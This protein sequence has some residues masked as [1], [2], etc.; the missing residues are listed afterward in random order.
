MKLGLVCARACVWPL[1]ALAGLAPR[2]HGLPLQA[3]LG[4][5]RRAGTGAGVRRRG[6]RGQRAERELTTWTAGQLC[7][8]MRK[9]AEE[10]RGGGDGDG[11]EQ[12]QG[13]RNKHS[14]IRSAAPYITNKSGTL[15]DS[16]TD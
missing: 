9:G 13:G 15:V 2:R 14:F 3:D 4:V 12:G 8:A 10:G 16:Y 11:E 1:A 6:R 7:A 5:G